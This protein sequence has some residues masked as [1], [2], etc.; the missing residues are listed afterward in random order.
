VSNLRYFI[1][2]L[3]KAPNVVRIVKCRRL[4]IRLQWGREGKHALG[5]PISRRQ[6]VKMVLGDRGCE[7]G[8]RI[9]MVGFGISSV[10]TWVSA[11]TVSPN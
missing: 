5:R 2:E 3:H 1:G 8:M 6:D 10:E 9:E 11:T 7:D 4:E